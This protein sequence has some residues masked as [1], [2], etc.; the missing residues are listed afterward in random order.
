MHTGVQQFVQI[1]RR[2]IRR[3]PDS[4][5]TGPI[6]QQVR[7]GRGQHDG[8]LQRAIVIVA[9]IDRVLGQPFQQRLSRR[10]HPRFG[11]A[12][13]RRVIAVNVAKVPLPVDQRIAHVEI[14]RQA[15]HR[16]IDRGIAV[17][18][19]VAHHVA[20]N[21]RR[22]AKSPGRRQLQLAHRIQNPPM[23]R[24]QPIAGIR[25]G[26]VHDGGQRIGQ[27]PL[28]DCAAQR[29]DKVARLS[30]GQIISVGHLIR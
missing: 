22:F 25:Q 9:I 24:L 8:F 14:L 2:D 4:D 18:V 1:M 30:A 5:S 21:L 15:R 27:I 29:F 12:R 7:K 11:I 28:A 20:G 6:G 26:A 3:H 10:R 19:V 23:H 17:R 16:V 13:R